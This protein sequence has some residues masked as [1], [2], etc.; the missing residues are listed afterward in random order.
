MVCSIYEDL[1]SP[2][3]DLKILKMKKGIIVNELVEI[4]PK[5]KLDILFKEIFYK[6]E[7]SFFEIFEKIGDGIFEIPFSLKDK[8]FEINFLEL[9]IH[10]FEL[11][12]KLYILSY[13]EKYLYEKNRIF[14]ICESTFING[15]ERIDKRLQDIDINT[16]IEN[17]VILLCKISRYLYD[18]SLNDADFSKIL[19]RLIKKYSLYFKDRK[20]GTNT[21][22]NNKKIRL[23]RMKFS[24]GVKQTSI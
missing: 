12:R 7:W 14:F 5:L 21:I 13:F 17:I 23:H 8:Q 10:Q 19:I 1:F 6:V 22:F 15:L 11:I 18:F 4:Y 2:D 20:N 9:N 16:Q 24:Y 3:D